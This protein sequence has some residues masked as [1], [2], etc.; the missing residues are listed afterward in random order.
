V[1]M[2]VCLPGVKQGMALPDAFFRVKKVPERLLQHKQ[3]H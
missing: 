2:P 1:E 3:L